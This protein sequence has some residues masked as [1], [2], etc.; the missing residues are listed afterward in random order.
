MKKV[1]FK[2]NMSLKNKTIL[3]VI[4][5]LFLIFLIVTTISSKISKKIIN[6]AEKIIK[7]ENISIINTAFEKENGDPSI[8]D[9]I[10]TVIKNEK[11]EI[12]EVNFNINECGEILINIV[13]NI[14]SLTSD[15]NENGYIMYI[16]LGYIS[17]SP[18]FVN[19]GPKIPVKIELTDIV[20]GSVK[21]KITDFGI[22]NALIE[23]YLYFELENNIILPLLDK[24]QNMS[25]DVLLTSKIIAG[26]V[27]EFYNGVLNSES[28]RIT[29]PINE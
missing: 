8:I 9:Q 4:I 19:L 21:T 25:F 18:L 13:K 15:Y 26:K 1:K 17:N 14:N 12:L 23:V 11:G 7:K 3:T 27:P 10:I 24:D 2:N 22:N 16:P 29:L 6:S 28:Q 5:T 20:T